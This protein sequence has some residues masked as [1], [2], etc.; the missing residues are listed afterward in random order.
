[1]PCNHLILC[2]PLLLLFISYLFKKIFVQVWLI[3]NVLVSGVQQTRITPNNLVFWCN[4]SISLSWNEIY[5]EPRL[6]IFISSLKSSWWTVLCYIQ[7][8]YI[9]VWYFII[10]WSPPSNHLLP[11]RVITILLAT[12]LMWYITLKISHNP[13]STNIPRENNHY[14]DSFLCTIDLYLS[15]FFEKELLK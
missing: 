6:F 12:F 1:M 2:H 4:Y 13:K 10:K 7:I 3:Y 9:K 11:Y 14:A 8:Y 15:G 5:Q